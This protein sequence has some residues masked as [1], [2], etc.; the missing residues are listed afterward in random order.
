MVADAQLP[1]RHE[2]A[3]FVGDSLCQLAGA[4]VGSP[5]I[6]KTL[7]GA[8]IFHRARKGNRTPL[9]FAYSANEKA[10]GRAFID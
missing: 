9:F 3:D 1:G 10:N 5:R 2:Q 4:H 7:P 6:R 8:T